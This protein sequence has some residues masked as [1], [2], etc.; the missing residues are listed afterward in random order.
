MK[1]FAALLASSAN[2]ALSGGKVAE[3][4]AFFEA[5]QSR[6]QINVEQ[7][8]LQWKLRDLKLVLL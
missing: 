5:N 2:A 1:T 6:Y 3:L 7:V 8:K 4:L